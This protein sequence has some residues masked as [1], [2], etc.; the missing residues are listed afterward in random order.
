MLTP[1]QIANLPSDTKKEYMQTVLLLEEK[2]QQQLLNLAWLTKEKGD[3]YSLLHRL[4]EN[5]RTC[6]SSEF[7]LSET[8]TG[9]LQKYHEKITAIFQIEK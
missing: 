7:T 9:R 2:K 4:N 6:S 5:G 3:G 8:E 1:E